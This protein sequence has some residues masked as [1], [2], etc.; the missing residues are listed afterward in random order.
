MV[1][2]TKK[3]VA[4]EG[5]YSSYSQL[6]LSPALTTASL[7]VTFC[8]VDIAAKRVYIKTAPSVAD[9]G[10]YVIL[11]LDNGSKIEEGTAY[12]YTEQYLQAAQSIKA[13]YV[14]III[15]ATSIRVYKDGSLLQT[16]TISG[17]DI[18]S[19]GISYN[20]EYIILYNYSTDK[21]YCFQGS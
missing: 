15:N 17:A 12:S 7:G 3:A 21:F 18:R 11:N 4:L 10:P 13:K 5:E 19:L 2:L 1:G 9:G 16:L 20:G 6:W 8:A 14:A